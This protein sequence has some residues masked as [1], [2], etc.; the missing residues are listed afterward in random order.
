[1]EVECSQVAGH[2]PVMDELL[3]TEYE[4]NPSNRSGSRGKDRRIREIKGR[5]SRSHFF[6][7]RGADNLQVRQN[8]GLNIFSYRLHEKVISLGGGGYE[9]LVKTRRGFV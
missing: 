4:Q 1:L 8:L 5:H 2:S 3:N 6:I 7:F 9:G